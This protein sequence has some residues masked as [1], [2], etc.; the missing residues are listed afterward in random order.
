MSGDQSMPL[1]EGLCLEGICSPENSVLLDHEYWH[2][3]FEHQNHHENSRILSQFNPP[4][5]ILTDSV[6]ASNPFPSYTY[7]TP[8][9]PLA[10]GLIL[11]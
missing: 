4:E 10:P 7:A 8:V 2:D 5:D 1:D 9:H 11:K 3:I 6:L